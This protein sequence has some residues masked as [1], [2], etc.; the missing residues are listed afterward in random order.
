MTQ[1]PPNPGLSHRE[2]SRLWLLTGLAALALV[3]ERLWP[4]VLPALGAVSLFVSVALLDVLA[5][6]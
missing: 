4:R 2:R 1:P 3:R 6:E 5:T